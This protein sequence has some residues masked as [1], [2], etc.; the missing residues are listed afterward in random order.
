MNLNFSKVEFH[1]VATRKSEFAKLLSQS[2]KTPYDKKFSN[3]TDCLFKAHNFKDLKFW[4]NP[5]N[6]KNPTENGK[7]LISGF[8]FLL[9]QLFERRDEREIFELSSRFFAGA[10]IGIKTN[11]FKNLRAYFEEICIR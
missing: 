5:L 1:S 6:L 3:Q 11:D 4:R 8:Y 2:L 7:D 10:Y 9:F